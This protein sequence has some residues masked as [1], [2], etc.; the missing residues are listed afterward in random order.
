MPSLIISISLS[1]LHLKPPKRIEAMKIPT[2][3]QS[4]VHRLEGDDVLPYS[5]TKV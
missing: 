2:F 5:K 1:L 4:A 3:P